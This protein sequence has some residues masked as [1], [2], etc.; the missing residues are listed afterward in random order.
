[1]AYL[2]ATSLLWAFSFGLVKG[3]LAGVDASAVA[4]LRMAFALALFA[5]FTRWR[6]LAPGRAL[7]LAGL[8]ALQF[9]AMY[10]LYLSAFHYLQ[11]HEVAIFTVFT[12][13]YVVLLDSSLE[14]RWRWNYLAAA[15]LALLGS[16]LLLGAQAFKGASGLGFLLMQA[17]NLAF[18]A[19][20]ILWCR[21]QKRPEAKEADHRV[22]GHL[23]LGAL[24]LS[25]LVSALMG[26]W[27]TVK[28]QPTQW[29]TLAY[30][31]LI[32]A[33]LCF[34]W[35]NLGARKVSAG[36]LAVMNNVKMPIAVA[37]SLLVFGEKAELPHL[38][39]GCTLLL[40]AL[41]VAERP[42]AKGS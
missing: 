33:G 28:L 12:P 34:Y 29:A 19:G 37:V 26:D 36:T 20:Q 41:F 40:L 2:L 17:C 15:L 7:R 11:A 23:Y 38:L 1:M 8:G 14:R 27:N 30:L 24:L 3:Q 31:G 16:G 21:E 10:L 35:W 22:M 4:V 25:A 5:P 13:L 6:G 39:G 9:G 42:K 18:A 32:P